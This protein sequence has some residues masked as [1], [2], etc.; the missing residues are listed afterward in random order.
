M[1]VRKGTFGKNQFLA[2]LSYDASCKRHI[3]LLVA[4]GTSSMA[5]YVKAQSE[6]KIARAT[7][8][9]SVHVSAV[10]RSCLLGICLA[11]SNAV[12]KALC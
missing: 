6:Q 12:S 2:L 7:V 11:R 1:K 4:A 8:L 3:Q 10:A 9:L 5:S